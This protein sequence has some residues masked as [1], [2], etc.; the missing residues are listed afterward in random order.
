M[1]NNEGAL[2]T[3]MSAVFALKSL[4]KSCG[5]AG[6]MQRRRH[7]MLAWGAAQRGAARTLLPDPA[8]S[9]FS[10]CRPPSSCLETAILPASGPACLCT[11]LR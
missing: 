8:H 11:C 10:G 5:G 4:Q 7:P 3:R 6:E 1:Q 2:R 9:A